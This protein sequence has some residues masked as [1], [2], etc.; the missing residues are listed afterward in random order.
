MAVIAVPS[1]AAACRAWVVK[2]LRLMS[3]FSMHK[4]TRAHLQTCKP[5]TIDAFLSVDY[6]YR[7]ENNL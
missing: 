3:T 1:T 7:A 4:F 2:A 6:N 5:N